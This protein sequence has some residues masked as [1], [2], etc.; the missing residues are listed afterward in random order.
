MVKSRALEFWYQPTLLPDLPE[1]KKAWITYYSAM[2]SLAKCIMSAYAEAL[3]LN[4]ACFNPYIGQP[5]SALR[6]LNYPATRSLSEAGQQRAGAHS[7]FGSLSI[8]LP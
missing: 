5:I 7:D 2:E 4:P 6:A 1:L 8:L 3:G